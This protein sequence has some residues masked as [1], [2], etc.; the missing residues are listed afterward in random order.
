MLPR[1]QA[2][3]LLFPLFRKY[4]ALQASTSN[5][6][7]LGPLLQRKSKHQPR[8]TTG[9]QKNKKKRNPRSSAP[10]RSLV[11]LCSRIRTTTPK[12]LQGASSFSSS[13]HQ[14]F[15][16]SQ[17]QNATS[18]LVSPTLLQ[19]LQNPTSTSCFSTPEHERTNK[20]N[21]AKL[22]TSPL[23]KPRNTEEKTPTK[24]K[25]STWKKCAPAS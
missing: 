4:A 5:S 7:Q 20:K 25:T 11:H 17:P 23:L 9:S 19:I 24:E 18:F 3:L 12:K 2:P 13:I 8:K 10:S 16:E 15:H 14:S 21:K 6:L 22:Q 1:P